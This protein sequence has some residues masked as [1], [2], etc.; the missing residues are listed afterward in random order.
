[1]SAEPLRVV[2]PMIMEVHASVASDVEAHVHWT[3]GYATEV[4]ADGE[5]FLL[6]HLHAVGEEGIVEVEIGAS[7]VGGDFGVL[8]GQEIARFEAALADGDSLDMLYGLARVT[9]AVLS[10]TIECGIVLPWHQPEAEI[11]PL[12]RAADRDEAP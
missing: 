3:V 7:Q 6:A 10:G 12:V 8:E 11:T 4:D 1:M 5:R 9:A 2:R